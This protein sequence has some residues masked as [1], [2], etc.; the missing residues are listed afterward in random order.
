MQ[1]CTRVSSRE[2]R[3]SFSSRAPEQCGRRIF[4]SLVVLCVKLISGS[5][6]VGTAL[7]GI[8]NAISFVI[9]IADAFM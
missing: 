7:L 5:S 6:N 8:I 2:N 1:S 9:C 3:W 4:N